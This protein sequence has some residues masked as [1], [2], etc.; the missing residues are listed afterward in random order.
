MNTIILIAIAIYL[1][2]MLAI[3]VKYADNK[4]SEDFYLGGRKLG[5]IVPRPRIWA[6]TC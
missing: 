5:P 4:T 6:R 2:G 3:G 1:I